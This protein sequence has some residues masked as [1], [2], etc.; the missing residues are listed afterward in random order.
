MK[1]I[2]ADE[3]A[4]LIKDGDTVATGG[5]VNIGFARSI[6]AAV[7]RRFKAIGKPH[8]ITLVHAAGQAHIGH[9]AHAGLL[10]RVVAGYY[11]WS[12]EMQRLVL[13]NEIEAY[14]L[15][16]G[17]LVNMYRDIAAGEK[18]HH[19][20]IGLGTFIEFDG[21]ALNERSK[22][23]LVFANQTGLAYRTF[24]IDV[25]II[26][27]D[28]LPLET[29]ALA[30]AAKNSGGI[31]ICE[32]ARNLPGFPSVLVDYLVLA[33]E[34]F[35]EEQATPLSRSVAQYGIAAEAAQFAN[36]GDIVNIG[37][38]LP[39]LVG[40]HLRGKVTMTTES[41][42]IGGLPA[43][44]QSFGAAK[45]MEYAIDAGSMFDFYNGGG[46]DVAFLGFAQVDK[47]GNVNVSRFGQRLP[48]CGGFI[49]ITQN[50]KRLVFV[51]T[52]TA[53]G[54]SKLVDYV[55]HLTFSGADALKRGQDV[56][57]VTDKKV[58]QLTRDG[59]V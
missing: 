59:L 24:P 33:S 26:K 6:A 58:Y 43:Q 50:T 37:I 32:S 36:A 12:K 31:V 45:N 20:K 4:S 21:G 8:G 57:V 47:R 22:D 17:V 5:F 25:A 27:P 42:T 10:K 7:E 28:V 1:I 13:D 44:G 41:G 38:G 3:A 14:N 39:E 48:G 15:P 51:G 2:T 55:S 52:E 23:H 56:R 29:M 54:E 18:Y 49:N 9:Y 53:N 46:L 40:E 19:S 11:G 35:P 34:E 30:M 16:Q